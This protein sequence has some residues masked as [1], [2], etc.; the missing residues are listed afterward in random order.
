[1]RL[2]LGILLCTAAAFAGEHNTLT[3][4]EKADGWQ[5]LFDGYS[6]EGWKSMKGSPFPTRSWTL[7]D[8]TIRTREG[9]HFDLSSE[10][11]YDNFELVFDF[12]LSPNGNSGIKYLVQ[13]EWLSPHWSPDRPEDW[14]AAQALSAVGYEYQIFDDRQLDKKPGWELSSMGAF[15]LVYAPEKKNPNPPGEWNTGRILVDGNHVEHWLNG[16]KMLEYEL[17]SEET[18]ERVAATKFRAVPGFGLKGPGNVVL[19]HHGAPAWFRNI[20]IRELD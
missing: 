11:Q 19:Q 16:E 7:E 17:G 9:A 6:F 20:K 3:S 5:L 13:H 15:Y 12:K 2:A 10:K 18:L 14:N 8:G 4:Q 1:M